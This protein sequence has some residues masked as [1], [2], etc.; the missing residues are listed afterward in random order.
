MPYTQL[1]LTEASDYDVIRHLI[2]VEEVDIPDEKIEMYPYLPWVEAEVTEVF[3]DYATLLST[4][5]TDKYRLKTGVACLTAAK[6]CIHMATTMPTEVHIGNYIERPRLDWFM[7]AEKLIAQAKAALNQI[8]T[9]ADFTRRYII[10]VAGPTRS[11]SNVPSEYEEWVERIQ[12]RIIDWVEE[13][14]EE[15]DSFF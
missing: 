9:K 13:G 14:G 10:A 15:D 5:G 2:D 3:T 12:P 1:V 6:L 4:G 8:S 7:L 11:E